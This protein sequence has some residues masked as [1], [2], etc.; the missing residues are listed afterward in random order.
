MPASD[1]YSSSFLSRNLT[2]AAAARFFTFSLLL[3][4]IVVVL[5]GGVVLFRAAVPAPPDFVSPALTGLVSDARDEAPVMEET[6]IAV[7]LSGPQSVASFDAITTTAT[8][9]ALQIAL[10]ASV[11][12]LSPLSAGDMRKMTHG[13]GSEI[14]GMK[15]GT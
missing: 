10:P 13:L 15:G 7:A 6:P 12:Q 4:V 11:P 8:D 3:H 1:L 9:S 2:R 14:G 5:A